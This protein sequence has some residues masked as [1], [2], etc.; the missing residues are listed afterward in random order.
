[1]Q[2]SAFVDG[3]LPENEAELL[4]RRLSQD[5]V[6]RQQ[7]AEYLAIGRVMRGE[8]TLK[9]SNALRERIV[10]ELDEGP[11]QEPAVPGPSKSTTRLIKPLAGIAIAASV[12]LVAIIGLRETVSV[13]PAATTVAVEEAELRTVPA[14]NDDGIDGFYQLHSEGLNTLDARYISAQMLADEVFGDETGETPAEDDDEVE[15]VTSKP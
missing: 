6:L 15:P 7:V 5:V 14:V 10:A 8:Y 1:M 11:L 12:A 13:D 2:V 9:G 4:V 3:E